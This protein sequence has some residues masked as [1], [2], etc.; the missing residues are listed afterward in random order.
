MAVFSY[1]L[2]IPEIR[3]AI[4]MADKVQEKILDNQI[5]E[6]RLGKIPEMDKERNYFQDNKSS[7]EVSLDP[8]EKVSFIK[9][10]ESLADITE[11]RVL[12]KVVEEENK[13][14]D[15]PKP[16]SAKKGAEPG[17]KEKLVYTNYFSLELN[18]RG[19]YKNLVN[20]VHRIENTY[21]YVNIIS[22]E[23]KKEKEK[24]AQNASGLDA[25]DV[26]L[27]QPSVSG[28]G[29]PKAED[30]EILNSKLNVIVYTRQ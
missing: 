4:S 20:F 10:L 25:M 12:I 5:F 23:I 22:L 15:K 3:N 11:N 19:E 2:I 9:K 13:I 1:L 29:N 24:D 17:I 28:T 8:D 26:F 18:I 27:A 16:S 6:K 30:K 21:N 7:L 14:S